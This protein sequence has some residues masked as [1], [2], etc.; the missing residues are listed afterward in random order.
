[1]AQPLIIVESPAKARTIARLLGSGYVVASSV[2]H[3]RDLPSRTAEIPSAHRGKPWA[4]TGVDVENDFKPLYVVPSEKAAQVKR[5]K[6]LLKQASVVYLA[7]DEDRE[8]EAIAWHLVEVLKP[9]VPVRR[10]VF[11]EITKRAVEQALRTPREVDRDLVEAQEAR[12]ILDRLYGYEVSPVLWRKIRP[13]LSA[14]RVQSVAVRL[15]VTREERRL[16]FKSGAYCSVALTLR[17]QAPERQGGTVVAE[18]QEVAGRRVAAGRHFAPSTGELTESAR[19]EQVLLLDESAAKG[20]AAA[21]QGRRSTVL[22]VQR[23]PFVQRPHPPFIT[24]TLQQEAGRKLGFPAQRTMRAAQRLY[25]SGY[26]TYMRTDSTTLS[27]EALQAARQVVT[28]L[29]G[30]DYLPAEARLYTTKVKGAQEAHEAIRPAGEVFRTPESL[31]GELDPEAARLYELIWKR[32]VASQMKDA[33]G[34]RTQVRIRATVAADDLPAP[35][36]ALAGDALLAV[37]G[38]V[39]RFAG[40]LRAYV[41]GSDDPEAELED[42]ERVLPPLVEGDPLM[43]EAAEVRQHVTQPPAR[44]TEA[45]LVKELEERGI[46]RPSTYA[47]I[48]Q[49]IQERG[50][51]WKQGSALVPTLTAFAVVRLL[52]SYFEDLVDYE[53]TARMENELDAIGRGEQ[54][55][56]PWLSRFYYGEDGPRPSPVVAIDATA[57]RGARKPRPVAP[58]PGEASP[59]VKRPA[60]LQPRARLA[61][62]GLMG[63]TGSGVEQIDAREVCAL[64]LGTLADGQ[65]LAARVG[66]YGPYLQVGDTDRRVSL[67]DDV[68]LDALDLAAAERML[69]QAEQSNRVLGVDPTSGKTV[70]IKSGSYGPYVQLDDPKLTPKGNVKK[71]SKPKMVSVWP[72]MRPETLTLDEALLLLSFPRILG[73]HPDTGL[74]VSVQDGRY[75][76]YV[77]MVTPEGR[78]ETRSLTGHEQLLAIALDEAV[79]LLAQPRQPSQ[80]EARNAVLARLGDSPTTNTPIEVRNG[81]FGP[82]VTDGQVNASVPRT[83]DPAKLTLDEA[84]ELLAVREQRLREQGVDPRAPR[85]RRRSTGAV[86][87]TT[88]ASGRTRAVGAAGGEGGGGEGAAGGEAAAE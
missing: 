32:A 13:G 77:S 30:A 39:L 21:L 41:E 67:A 36:R 65:A 79:A 40:Y 6:D 44:Y 56:T 57:K 60:A 85:P 46:G 1:M 42:K 31:R 45:S 53:F 12:R 28:E 18:L 38:Q 48:I 74:E 23:K 5:L 17:D 54:P 37:S 87:R 64:P 76:P 78:L 4:R 20:L 8:G 82:Y 2:G 47:S 3:I 84:L 66:R 58:A 43:A 25:E 7:T 86:R 22:E 26:I 11:H 63:L 35:Q 15:V 71:G 81:R 49:T 10:M 61:E 33:V 72:T 50:Y 70:Y 80:R 19:A 52:Q 55:S 27:S 83:R 75:G 34:E 88:R 62:V 29:F 14:G 69:Q 68:S 16:A 9:K 24:S 59:E 51:V 73:K